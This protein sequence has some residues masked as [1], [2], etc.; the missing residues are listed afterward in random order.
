[1]LLAGKS[2]NVRFSQDFPYIFSPFVA[3]VQ[4]MSRL[5]RQLGSGG[6]RFRSRG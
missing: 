1:V 6:E 2:E 4:S 5:Q 3:R